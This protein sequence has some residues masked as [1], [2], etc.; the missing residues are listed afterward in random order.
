MWTDLEVY[1][2]FLEIVPYNKNYNIIYTNLKLN[3]REIYESSFQ[4]FLRKNDCIS[5]EFV[6]SESI[7]HSLEDTL[8]NFFEV[9]NNIGPRFDAKKYKRTLVFQVV[10]NDEMNFSTIPNELLEMI[11]KNKLFLRICCDFLELKGE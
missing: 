5:L 2:V 8:N 4:D 7:S 9:F 3:S 11:Q 6:T 10:F 1:K